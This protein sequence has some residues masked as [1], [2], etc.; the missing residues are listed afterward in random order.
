VGAERAEIQCTLDGLSDQ[1]SVATAE[2]LASSSQAELVSALARITP[3]CAPGNF[4]IE[5]TDCSAPTG[6]VEK[7][8]CR[9]PWG[10]HPGGG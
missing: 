6:R 5:R 3:D 8:L 1:L 10:S 4:T 7:S 9:K 2:E